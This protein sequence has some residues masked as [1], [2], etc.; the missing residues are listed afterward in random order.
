MDDYIKNRMKENGDVYRNALER[1]VQKYS[2]VDGSGMEVCLQSMTCRTE[3]GIQPWDGK[4]VERQ[5]E[6]L[7]R[8]AD[9]VEKSATGLDNSREIQ[10]DPQT[11][12][13]SSSGTMAAEMERSAES[14][15]S[16]VDSSRLL[17]SAV[18]ESVLRGEPEHDDQ[19]EQTL[20]SL[21]SSL[22]ALYPSMLSQLGQAWRRQQVTDA[23]NAVLRRYR[24][25]GWHSSTPRPTP[26][27]LTPK[28]SSHSVTPKPSSHSVT[29]RLIPR[30]LTPK[31][32]SHSVT[33]RSIPH[34]VTPKPSSH[35]V[36]PRP[37]PRSVTPKPLT[38]LQCP[39]PRP[40]HH[41]WRMAWQDGG[42]GQGLVMNTTRSPEDLY[43]LS[44]TIT[45]SCS[46]SEKKTPQTFTLSHSPAQKNTSQI[47]TLPYSPSRP[48]VSAPSRVQ[49][50]LPLLC[51]RTPAP[52]SGPRAPDPQRRHSCSGLQ[53]ARQQIDRQFD[54]LYQRLVCQ[55]R[56]AP[57]QQD[58]ALLQGSASW[59]SSSLAA[60]ALSP[61]G[62]RVRKRDRALEPGA[63]PESKRFREPCAF[64]PGWTWQQHAHQLRPHSSDSHVTSA[65]P[66][67]REEG[68]LQ[69]TLSKFEGKSVVNASRS[70][71]DWRSGHHSSST[72]YFPVRQAVQCP[73]GHLG[74]RWLLRAGG[75]VSIL[76]SFSTVGIPPCTADTNPSTERYCTLEAPA[77]IDENHSLSCKVVGQSAKFL[78]H[79]QLPEAAA[80]TCWAYPRAAGV[81]DSGTVLTT[82][83]SV[84]ASI[85]SCRPQ[86]CLTE[87]T[88]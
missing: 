46:P 62:T 45:L 26:R 32:S 52:P 13:D 24:R 7:K 76:S 39:T 34:S 38:P 5:M 10:D 14:R 68:F 87:Y 3:K 53:A 84:G 71:K 65:A 59:S 72:G 88:I 23:A 54:E 41:W 77:F 50:Q 33:P 36:T 22:L 86:R 82:S 4:D 35:S 2:R 69:S 42:E 60:L 78:G 79:A 29:P 51:S 37:T 20:S 64:S 61:L 28:P 55:G 16:S 57:P 25:R 83:A 6:S 66:S 47:Y 40:D 49:P 18:S 56:V 15:E 30:S 1:I 74:L 81:A 8:V 43:P 80:L 9:S 70:L 27:S 73:T 63:C 58:S 12:S 19:L 85:A 67:V 44:Q 48:S 11:C 75:S 17:N 21:G 31:P